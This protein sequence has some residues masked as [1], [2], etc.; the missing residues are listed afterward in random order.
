[1]RLVQHMMSAEAGHG[2]EG[3]AAANTE[4]AALLEQPFPRENAVMPVTLVH[5]EPE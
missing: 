3:G 2:F 5:V 1:M 4:F